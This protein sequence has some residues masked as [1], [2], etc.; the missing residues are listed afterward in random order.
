MLNNF[1]P[2][3]IIVFAPILTH[4][5]YP[6]LNKYGIRFPRVTRCIFGFMLAVACGAVGAV[7]Q[8]RVYKTSPCGYYASDCEVGTGVS[9][10]SIWWQVPMYALGAMSECL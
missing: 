1:N 8:Y 3:T 5:V 6:A 4:F 9:P 10:I 7:L 2:L